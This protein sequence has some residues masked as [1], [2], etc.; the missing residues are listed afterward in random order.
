M[1]ELKMKPKR[2]IRKARSYVIEGTIAIIFCYF[3]LGGSEWSPLLWAAFAIV[4]IWIVVMNVRH[5]AGIE[6]DSSYDRWKLQITLLMV[7]AA[8]G[9]SIWRGSIWL[10]IVSIALGLFW[11]SDLR[12]YKAIH[13][14]QKVED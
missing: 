12:S 11:F 9:A 1:D 6:S 8:L 13:G 4:A 2:N 5:D 7:L 14:K 10:L 3:V